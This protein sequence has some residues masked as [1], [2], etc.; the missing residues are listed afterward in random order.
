MQIVEILKY[1]Q[2][3]ENSAFFYTPNLYEFV[4]S[5]LFKEPCKILKGKTRE[6]IKKIFN[7]VDDLIL[8]DDLLGLIQSSHVSV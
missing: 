7:V 3:N 2:E 4:K 8:E 6:D 1:V 5:Y